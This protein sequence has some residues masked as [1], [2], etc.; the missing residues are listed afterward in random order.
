MESSKRSQNRRPSSGKQQTDKQTEKQAEKQQQEMDPKRKEQIERCNTVNVSAQSFLDAVKSNAFSEDILSVPP[1]S[2]DDDSLTAQEINDAIH[3]VELQKGKKQRDCPS[4]ADP[5]MFIE[6]MGNTIIHSS[7]L[8]QI[9]GMTFSEKN[10][11]ELLTAY[12]ISTKRCLTKGEKNCALDA[13]ING[14]IKNISDFNLVL[15]G[16]GVRGEHN[17]IEC[18]NVYTSMQE[19][20]TQII[21]NQREFNN[22]AKALLDGFHEAKTRDLKAESLLKKPMQPIVPAV[23][24]AISIKKQI[25]KPVIPKMV[26]QNTASTPESLKLGEL[27]YVDNI[28]EF[29]RII[30]KRPDILR[31][32]SKVKD[33]DDVL[34]TIMK[35]EKIKR[36][37]ST[38]ETEILFKKVLKM[39]EII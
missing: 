5:K 26:N 2:A 16:Y 11:H 24:P 37:L 25:I 30:G 38:T 14:Y 15:Y 36:S 13:L 8:L 19:V 32:S 29:C 33:T 27:G 39:L 23:I 21:S 22:R 20:Q 7:S 35:T 1:S 18:R 34:D 9:P 4:G 6:D 10:A 28:E 17:V 12:E 31:T 3:N